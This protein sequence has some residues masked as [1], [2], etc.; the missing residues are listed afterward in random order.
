MRIMPLAAL[1]LLA[2]AAFG[3]TIGEL[4]PSGNRSFLG[5]SGK[6]FTVI[7]FARPALASG[8]VS[9]S[10][11][12]WTDG[13]EAG[14][15]SAIKLKFFRY[16]AEG[17]LNVTAERGPF[18]VKKG[19]N[20]YAFDDVPI[21]RNDFIGLTMLNGGSACGGMSMARGDASN[22]IGTSFNDPIGVATGYSL[23]SGTIPN[24]VA[25][26]TVERVDRYIVV[27][28][29]VHGNQGSQFKTALQ[30]TNLGS[31]TISGKLVFHPAGTQAKPSDPTYTFHLEPKATDSFDDV[32][33][34]LDTT[35]LGSMD[36][37]MING[38][39][40]DI[41][42]RIY[43]DGGTDGTSGLTEEARPEREAFHSLDSGSLTIP[44]DLAN[45]RLNIGYRTLDTQV[46]VT[47]TVYDANGVV[48]P[49]N[50]TMDLSPNTFNQLSVAQ[51]VNLPAS[52]IPAGGFISFQVQGG[53]AFFYGATTDNRTNDPNLQSPIRR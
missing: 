43:N 17:A 51:F 41:T 9:H 30:M 18:S 4:H 23:S 12:M 3:V 14:C 26:T 42:V 28:G 46:H 24:I 6:P 8:T 49:S 11:V 13:P 50:G 36:V 22:A 45:F 5:S 38:Y 29:S 1:C 44:A 47:S 40:P 2:P 25:S 27:A 34:E 39:P 53:A 37:V 52:S 35:G 32:V 19:I 10:T 31:D 15:A 7:D 21:E 20:N 33:A 16:S 48:V